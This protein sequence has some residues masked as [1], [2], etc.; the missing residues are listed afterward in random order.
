M[1]QAL[2]ENWVVETCVEL[3]KESPDIGLGM[4]AGRCLSNLAANYECHVGL[5]RADAAVALATIVS[6][7]RCEF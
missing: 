5:L 1:T 4:E 3:I 7:A 6:P 2:L